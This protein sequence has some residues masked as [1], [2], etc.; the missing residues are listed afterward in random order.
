MKTA[1]FYAF[2]YLFAFVAF[3]LARW[4]FDGILPFFQVISKTGTVYTYCNYIWTASLVVFLIFSAFW[5]WNKLKE[6][7][8]VGR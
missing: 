4:L 7:Q 8:Y 1:V 2:E 6:W 3:G 5:F